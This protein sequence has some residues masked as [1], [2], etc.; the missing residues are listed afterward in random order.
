MNEKAKWNMVLDDTASIGKEPLPE[1]TEKDKVFL[2]KAKSLKEKY[3][4]K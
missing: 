2:D 1:T 3:M 4:K